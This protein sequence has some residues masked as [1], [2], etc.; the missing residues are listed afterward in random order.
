MNPYI[1]AFIDG[2]SFV[3]RAYSTNLGGMEEPIT[4][5]VPYAEVPGGRAE[6]DRLAVIMNADAGVHDA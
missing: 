2:R 6:A 1:P 4:Y 3:L 5:Y